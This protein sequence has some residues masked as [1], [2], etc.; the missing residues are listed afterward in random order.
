MTLDH[1]P[2]G[3]TSLTSYYLVKNVQQYLHF[4]ELAFNAET[5]ESIPREDG[6]IMHAEVRIGNSL[7]MIGE[8]REEGRATKSMQY[9]YVPDVDASYKHVLKAGAE[10]IQEPE[11]QFYGHRTCALRDPYGNEWWLASQKEALD[12]D[13]I[14]KRAKE[15]QA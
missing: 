9:M 12:S 7:L 5:T 8:A 4:L 13:E 6:T 10:S 15:A 3:Y 1:L 2:D 11:D 14:A